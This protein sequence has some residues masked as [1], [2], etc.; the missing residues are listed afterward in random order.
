MRETQ[1]PIATEMHTPGPLHDCPCNK[2]EHF[3]NSLPLEVSETRNVRS[4]TQQPWVLLF[5]IPLK[6]SNRGYL[7][8][9]CI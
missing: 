1:R 7:H 8:R 3:P 6:N 4:D 9:T 5:P 2:H